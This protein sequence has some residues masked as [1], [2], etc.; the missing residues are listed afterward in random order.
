MSAIGGIWAAALTPFTADFQPDAAR[1]IP[2][3]RELL[4]NGCDG[5]NVLG[6][7][8]EAMSLS[9]EQRVRYMQSLACS[10][11]PM[12]RMM[13][14]TGAAAL[15]DAVEL[16]RAALDCGFAAALIMP[17]FFYR[18]ASD[19]GIAAFFHTLFARAMPPRK[20]VLLYN[21]PRMA[22]VVLHADLVD[23]LVDASRGRIFG[24]KDSSNDARLQAEIIGRR[25]EIL[26]LSRLG[27]RSGGGKKPRRRRMHLGQRRAMAAVGEERLR[28]RRRGAHLGAASPARGARGR[29]A[30]RRD[31]LSYRSAARRARVGTLDAAAGTAL[32]RATGPARSRVSR[33]RGRGDDRFPMSTR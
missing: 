30:R 5:I 3:Y 13:A 18:E 25:P 19:D 12:A 2:Y 4:E 9:V 16:T 1:A 6:T 27:E 15:D 17:P 21:F 24:M 26:D 29:T 28:R 14:G 10:G 22:G 8:G 11:L 20:S 33:V 32:G 31:A 7:T 23:R